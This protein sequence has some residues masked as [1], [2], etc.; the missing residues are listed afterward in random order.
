MRRTSDAPTARTTGKTRE[1]PPRE[2][3]PAAR[4]SLPR[5][6]HPHKKP[7]DIP[8]MLSRIRA[9]VAPYPK[10]ALFE[11]YDL[12][13]TTPFEILVACIISIRT[14]DE[15][16]TPTAQKLFSIART[17]A[18]VAHLSVAQID[19]AI[20]AATFHGPKAK[21]IHEIATRCVRDF[22][23]HLPCDY[24]T[25]TS[26]HG[27]G[28]KCANLTLGIT[29]ASADTPPAGIGVDIHVHR[30]THRWGYT[31]APTPEKTMIQLHEKLPKE[32]WVE[33][34]AL[35]VPFGKHVCTGVLP[36]CSTCPVFEYC[37]QVG[38]ANHR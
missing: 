31:Q 9:A 2:R 28:P 3:H 26:F 1:R 29:C 37:R 27:V 19:Y 34:N 5:P 22:N 20:R 32:Y 23:G 16:T 21:T 12:G 25:L 24:E 38:V 4:P 35:L 33:I 30:V 8:E 17:P 10:A 13:H 18:H 14:R 11:L 6:A 7:H 36:H 15:T